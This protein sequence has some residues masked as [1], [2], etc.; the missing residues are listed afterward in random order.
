MCLEYA[1]G[2]DWYDLMWYLTKFKGIEPNYVMLNNAMAQ[3][4]KEPL[5][6]TQENWKAEIKKSVKALDWEKV[7]DDV[8][9]FLE[10]SSDLGLLTPETFTNLLE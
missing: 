4:F 8:G 10:D 1:E 2:R 6:I 7:R 3:T 9:K 5:K